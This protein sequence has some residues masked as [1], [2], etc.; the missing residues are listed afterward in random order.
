ML[1]RR[2][3]FRFQCPYCGS[4]FFLVEASLMRR[5]D[6]LPFIT[7]MTGTLKCADCGLVTS[8]DDFVAQHRGWLLS[9]EARVRSRA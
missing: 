8:Y 7:A 2:K 9:P 4:T 5:R 3:P 1:F 6:R